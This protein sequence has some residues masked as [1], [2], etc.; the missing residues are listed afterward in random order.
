MSD[1]YGGRRQRYVQVQ[2]AGYGRNVFQ[3]L[4]G[5]GN[6]FLLLM[7]PPE[8]RRQSYRL[9]SGAARKELWWGGGSRTICRVD[10]T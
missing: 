7:G 3:C 8:N 4:C 5:G 1:R 9:V 2:G 10:N 6:V